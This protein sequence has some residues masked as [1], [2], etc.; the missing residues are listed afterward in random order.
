MYLACKDSAEYNLGNSVVL[1]LATFLNDSYCTL[2][3][4]N[5]FSSPHL[6][7]TLFEKNI[8]SV[9]TIRTNRKNMPTFPPDKNIERGDC[10]F[11]T[12]KNVICVKWMDNGAVTLIGSNVLRRQKGASSKSAVPYP[13]IVKKYLIFAIKILWNIILTDDPNF[14]F[15]CTYFLI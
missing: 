1:N 8:Y 5:F 4:D 12:C 11:K 7:Q 13:I 2:H 14:V 6:I 9:G 15:A 10:K 3:L